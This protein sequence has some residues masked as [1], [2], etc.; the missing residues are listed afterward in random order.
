MDAVFLERFVSQRGFRVV[1]QS[2]FHIGQFGKIID[3][4][5][6]PRM[7]IDNVVV[8]VSIS[9]RICPKDGFAKIG[10]LIRNSGSAGSAGG[11]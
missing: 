9:G 8:I 10:F 7:I 4:V 2:A 1:S 3:D 6:R 5:I 11:K